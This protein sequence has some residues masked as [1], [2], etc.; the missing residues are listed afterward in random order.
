MNWLI[1][2]VVALISGVTG[3]FLAGFIANACTSWYHVSSREGASGYFV[4]FLAIGGGI[5]GV[6]VGFIVAR[7]VA[8]HFG[9]GFGKELA[10]ALGAVLLIAGV[11]ALLARVFADVPPEIDGR[12]LILEVEFRFPDTLSSQA[13]PTAKGEWLFQLASLSGHTQRTY[14]GGELH[15]EKARFV[16]KRWIVP[17]EVYL[18]T[19]RG[20]RVIDLHRDGQDAGGFLLNL[21]GRPGREFL[22]WSEWLPRQQAD[23]QPWPAEKLSYRFRVQKTVPPPPPQTQEEWMAE[24]AAKE[25]AE[26]NSIPADSPIVAWFRYTAYEQPLTQRALQVIAGRPHLVDELSA[27]VVS[28]DPEKAHAAMRCIAQLPAPPKELIPGLQ[29]AARVITTNI[30]KFNNTPKEQDPSFAMAVDPATRFYGWISA[31]QTLREK[32]GGDF[33]AELKTILEL[34]RVR[35]ESHCMRQDICRVA[36]FYLHEWAGIEPLPTDPKPK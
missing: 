17:A 22:E 12:D 6:I 20:K 11:S 4:L 32:C 29:A 30:T 26:F 3:L 34:S 23:G 14:R 13:P 19:G 8:A 36:S 21:P 2:L 15:T 24:K 18:F 33:T 9:Q 7:V 28:D 5:A 1:S 16:D 25:E 10:G 35:P 31:V 27:L